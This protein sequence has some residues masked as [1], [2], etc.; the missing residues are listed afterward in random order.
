M[1]K[2]QNTSQS[3]FRLSPLQ[4]RLWLA[5]QDGSVFRTQCA[6]L[7]EGPLDPAALRDAVEKVVES[8]EILRTTFQRPSGMKVPL[9]VIH[10]RLPCAWQSDE[11]AAVQGSD[12][13]ARLAAALQEEGGR[14]ADGENTSPVRATLRTLSADRHAL[15][16]SLPTLC[17][18]RK[19]LANF[20]G[21][22]RQRYAGEPAAEA[23]VQYA[24][25]AEWR[26][27]LLESDDEGARAA[28]KFW[29]ELQALP[30]AVLP[31]QGKAEAPA[32]FIPESVSVPAPEAVVRKAEA[33]ARESETSTSVVLLA[34]WSSLLARLTGQED[35]VVRARFD[36]RNQEEL[37]GAMGLF[38]EALPVRT[39]IEDVPFRDLVGQ[40]RQATEVASRRQEYYDEKEGTAPTV[41]FEVET[42][43]ARAQASGV[44]FSVRRSS[45]A[46][47]RFTLRVNVIFAEGACTVELS[48]D[49]R[50]FGRQD[51]QRFAGYF[52]RLLQSV[53]ADPQVSA[54]AHDLPDEQERQRLLVDF[55]RTAADYPR[56]RCIHELFEEQAG[57]TPDRIALVFEGRQ[58]TYAEL[59][60]RANRLAHL[61]RRRGVGRNV[62]V[63]LC[64][65]RS[66]EMLVAVLGI[67]KAGGA[68][69]PL[70][71]EHPRA[72]LAHQMAE[73]GT[74]LIV[75]QEKLLNRLPDFAGEIFCL[76]RDVA[77][78]ADHP[79]A[80]PARI[81]TPEDLVYVIYTSGSTGTPK[82]V[83]NLHRN[84]VNYTHFIRTRLGLD[85]PENAGGLQF[86]T[87]S[88]LS[89]DLGNTCIFPALVSGGTLQV[90]SHETSMDGNLFARSAAGRPIDVLK[91]TPSH[92]SALLGAAGAAV[93]PRRFLILGGEACSWEL[94]RQVRQ[95]GA[96]TIFNHYG[97]TETTVG[98]LTF[99]VS[100][101]E[102]PEAATVPVGRPIAN[103]E[104]YILDNNRKPLPQGAP[105][106]LYI[107]GAGVAQGYLNQPTQTAERFVP[108]AFS[109]DPQ[110]RL[111]RTGDRVRYLADGNVEFLGRVDHQVKIRGF[112]VEPGE[113]E[114]VL[115]RHPGI[116]Q[117]IVVALDGQGGD[118]RLVG[119]VVPRAGRPVKEEEVRGFLAQELPEY[120]VPA[121][122]VSL[123]VLPRTPNGKVDRNALPA[124]DAGRRVKAAYVGPRTPV[125]EKLVAIW[126][127]VLRREP[128][129]VHD[130][131]FELGG[132]SLLATQVVSRVCSALQVQVPLRTLFESPT[133]ACLA[134][135]VGKAQAEQTDDSELSHMLAELEGLS[136][137]EVQRL[138]ALEE[139]V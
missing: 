59:N 3:G 94:V 21:E 52:V 43:P 117:A 57:R 99:G 24:D 109:T 25:F 65:E 91:I 126:V 6:V 42:L 20:V 75:T 34:C 62:P 10:D 40:V 95:A 41:A 9:Q 86:A 70:H 48:Y 37:Q 105:G 78:L 39:R 64:L 133:V 92:L 100:N 106:E 63:G 22:I 56:D 49:P 2:M 69:V 19:A 58:W 28:K 29:A 54:S 127:E 12:L 66:G 55:N 38:A 23:P 115:R 5:Q 120:M 11:A 121:V 47:G 7:L 139:G 4:R 72:R 83:G 124:P 30:A 93:L 46:L 14:P 33:L 104:V 116:A 131:F 67:L 136:E 87:V 84:L 36:G 113:V 130:D 16:L 15:L 134:E 71:F 119:Y 96:C 103:T 123:D 101:D 1:Q 110:A 53:T 88:T 112:R 98:S 44:V 89:A 50:L 122:L 35:V 80:N 128:I 132:H 8:H 17:A 107:G 26:N 114:A 73:A 45:C 138:L 81:S 137:E 77:L 27:Q 129:G 51:V 31:G 74:P 18:D 61:L 97:P 79:E 68:Y 90:I 125:E 118:R 76:D 13:D 111:Y 102:V 135:V 82:G 85:L 32:P 60:A 108:H